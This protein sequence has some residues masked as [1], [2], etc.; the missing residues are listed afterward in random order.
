MCIPEDRQRR[1]IKAKV[2]STEYG[3]KTLLCLDWETE[4]DGPVTEGSFVFTLSPLAAQTMAD[5]LCGQDVIP[6]QL[7]AQVYIADI[8]QKQGDRLLD[9]VKILARQNPS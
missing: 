4:D 7:K 2:K 3:C 1:V 6:K 9:V 8:L 5:G